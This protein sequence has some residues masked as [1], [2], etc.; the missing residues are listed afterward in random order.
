M[1]VQNKILDLKKLKAKIALLKKQGKEIAFTNGCFDLIHYGH[2]DYLEKAKKGNRALIVGLNSDSSVRRLKGSARPIV[3]QKARAHVMAALACVDFVIV[4]NEETP[5]NLIKSIKPDVL[6]KG[7]DWKGKK[8]AGA[9]VVVKNK[10]KLQ[11]IRYIPGFS[12]TQIIG[13]II[14][15]CASR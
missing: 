9:D 14:K 1:S 7:A 3:N 2:V 13:K 11:F 5:L 10:G 6:I 4:F 15:S 12:T 8:V